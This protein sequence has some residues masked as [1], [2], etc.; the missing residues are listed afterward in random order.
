[1]N[2]TNRALN[3]IVLAVT[4]L[5]LVVVGAAVLTTLAW[6]VAA[7]LWHD[8]ARATQDWFASAVDASRI[9]GS[10][11][12]WIEVALVAAPIVLAVLLL[13]IPIR[14]I[15]RRSHPREAGVHD[16]TPLG[17]IV[18]SEDFA[19]D[20][21]RQSLTQRDEILAVNVGVRQTR[22]AQVLHV[23]VTP[24]QSTPP[25]DVTDTVDR[26]LANLTALTGRS[27]PAVISIHSGLRTRLAGDQ[28]RVD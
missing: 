27:L 25:L 6:P 4:G 10:E 15:A 19:S 3:R 7:T 18:V 17:R 2:N 28:R 26:L 20:A 5:V 13:L 21:I 16:E 8:G 9:S 24:R 11:V 14:V 1:M 22:A 23:S 12:S